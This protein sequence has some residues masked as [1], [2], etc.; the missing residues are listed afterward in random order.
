[1]PQ[2]IIVIHG[3]DSFATYEDYIHSLE[4]RTLTS[5]DDLKR[6]GWKATLGEV[7]GDAYDVIVP[8]M[9]NK[10]NAKYNEWKIWFEKILPLVN[11]DAIFV[12]HSMGGIFLVKYFSEQMYTKNIKALFLVSAPHEDI[13]GEP[14]GDFNF[15]EDCN[16]L[17]SKTKNIFLYH[18]KDDPV[19]PFSHGERYSQELTGSF[20]RIFENRSHLHQEHFPEIVDDIRSIKI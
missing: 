11:D 9:P 14:L 1:M 16:I 8:V 20:F 13:P 7:L 17:T 6:K 3:A 2:Q 4:G 5:L 15:K 12:G 10:D 18:S 19:V